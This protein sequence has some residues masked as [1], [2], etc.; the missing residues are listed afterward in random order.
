MDFEQLKKGWQEQ[1]AP[2]VVIDSEREGS[3]MQQIAGVRKT[4]VRQNVLVTLMLLPVIGVTSYIWVLFKADFGWKF[5]LSILLVNVVIVLSLALHWYKTTAWYRYDFTENTQLF[6]S[7]LIER[8][9][10]I[11]WLSYTG[12]LIYVI[13]L[14]AILVLYIGEV[15]GGYHTAFAWYVI[16]ATTPWVIISYWWGAARQKKKDSKHT[17]PLLKELEELQYKINN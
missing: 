2:Q 3:L 16:G 7:H 6:L 15:A 9:K 5:D 4:Y 8:L 11:K 14:W 1:K 10:L 12:S 17:D 13:A